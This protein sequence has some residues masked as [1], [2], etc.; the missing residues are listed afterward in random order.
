MLGRECVSALLGRFARGCAS[1]AGG[2]D[3]CGYRPVCI[4]VGLREV[5]IS[6]QSCVL[7]P[8]VVLRGAC[9]RASEVSRGLA[10]YGT[11]S[12][13]DIRLAGVLLSGSSLV[14]AV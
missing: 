6:S 8:G 14:R 7:D 13:A 11:F 1:Y 2:A 5:I 12:F 9:S 4:A 3:L 10:K